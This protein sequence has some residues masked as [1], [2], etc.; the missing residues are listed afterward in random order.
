MGKHDLA[1]ISGKM[2]QNEFLASLYVRDEAIEVNQ[3]VD[4]FLTR[5][6][7][8]E[9]GQ[10]IK[11]LHLDDLADRLLTH[12]DLTTDFRHFQVLRIEPYT[13]HETLDL[14]SVPFLLSKTANLKRYYA[15]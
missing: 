4:Q 15:G 3:Y 14:Q 6:E 9:I 2:D 13:E 12:A 10:T 5:A 1:F 7:L 8:D 11:Q